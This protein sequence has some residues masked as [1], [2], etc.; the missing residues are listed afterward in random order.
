MTAKRLA[1]A[2]S[3][4]RN[5]FLSVRPL[6]QGGGRTMLGLLS[7]AQYRLCS[8]TNKASGTFFGG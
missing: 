8:V 4:S 6:T 2:W 3:V 7:M 5:P 1:V